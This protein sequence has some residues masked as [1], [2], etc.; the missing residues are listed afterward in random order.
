MSKPFLDYSAYYKWCECQFKWYE[1]Y[2]SQHVRT[3]P[4]GHVDTPLT[5]G[6]C[7]HAGLEALRTSG[8]PE[9][10]Q[11]IIEETRVSP[12]YAGW[13]NA[14]V[15]GYAA[16]YPG[17]DF[18]SGHTEEPLRFP[19]IPD[20]DGLAKVDYFWEVPEGG[21]YIADGL[22]GQLWLEPGW[23]IKE[24]KTKDASRNPGNWQQSWRMNPQADF[25]CHALAAKIG[26]A[27][28]GVLVDTLEKPKITE[29]QRTCTKCH[30]KQDLRSY[31]PLGGGQF[32][33]PLCGAPNKI[34]LKDKTERKPAFYRFKVLRSPEQLEASFREMQVIAQEMAFIREGSSFPQRRLTE[35]V[36]SIFGACEYFE[37]HSALREAATWE[38]FV[39]V[40]TISYI[41]EKNE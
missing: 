19:L 4:P 13:A 22:G 36:N 40:N 32:G 37:P 11:A 12:E 16:H 38:G 10:P 3:P 2:V 30:Q 14:L 18:P 29:P 7:V 23:W 41:G 9:V 21:Q 27:P 31:H 33:C 6:S 24:Y 20:V 1:H 34:P 25:Q 26:V 8:I 5:L 17:E 39:K 35:C 28:K 15:Q